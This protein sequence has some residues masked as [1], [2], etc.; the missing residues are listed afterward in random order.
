M[1]ANYIKRVELRGF[2]NKYNIIW[3][4]LNPDVNILVG[5]NGSGKSSILNIIHSVL[6]SD[7]KIISKYLLKESLISC[8]NTT[9]DYGNG[10]F[11]GFG[12]PDEVILPHI[13]INTFDVPLSNKKS[14]KQDESPLMQELRQLILQ[15]GSN[16][17]ND[18]R[19]KAFNSKN[20]QQI[21]SRIDKFFK[22]ID[23]LFEN[24]GKKIQIDSSNNIIF[25]LEDSSNFISLEQLSSGEKQLLLI[26]FKVFLMDEQPYILLMDEPEISLHVGWQQQLVS[27]IRE[28]NPNCQVILATHSPSI[29]AKGWGDKVFFVENLF[30]EIQL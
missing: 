3:D 27:V 23:N 9:I 11:G 5:I 28:I 29:F 22:L 7:K 25:K 10:I 19:L 17:F 21:K 14:I 16:S 20:P 15:T 1:K 18:F 8:G 2:W 30:S 4:N 24:T 6:S 12:Y 13:L 26:L